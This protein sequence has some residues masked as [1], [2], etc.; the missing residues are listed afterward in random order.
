MKNR[1]ILANAG[2]FDVEVD[3]EAT[4]KTALEKK[5]VRKNIMGY[6][7][8]GGKWINIMAEG[9]LVNI[10]AADG[11]PAEIMD[12]S[13]A[14]QIFS[15]LYIKENHKDL[16]K[17]VIDVSKDIDKSIAERKLESWGISIDKLT[18]EQR[19]YLNS[20]RF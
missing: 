16:A 5:E 10:A 2:H 18:E 17:K 9:R 13:F 6:K 11:H 1:A 15:A 12:L 8:P 20:W 3:V 14:V 19:V 7:M 4:E